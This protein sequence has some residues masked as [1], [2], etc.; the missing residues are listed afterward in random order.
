MNAKIRS[1]GP[2]PLGQGFKKSVLL[3]YH[4]VR[5]VSQHFYLYI[6]NFSILNKSFKYLSLQLAQTISSLVLPARRYTIVYFRYFRYILSFLHSLFY[7]ILLERANVSPSPRIC[8]RQPG[9]PSL[10]HL[11]G[12]FDIWVD[13]VEEVGPACQP[14]VVE[15]DLPDESLVPVALHHLRQKVLCCHIVAEL[16]QNAGLDV[17]RAPGLPYDIIQVSGVVAEV[18]FVHLRGKQ[19]GQV[20][21]VPSGP[22][23]EQVRQSVWVARRRREKRDLAGFDLGQALS[24]IHQVVCQQVCPELKPLR[25]LVV[26]GRVDAVQVAVERF[27]VV[28]VAAFAGQARESVV[29]LN[30]RNV[31]FLRHLQE[32]RGH[33]ALHLRV[34]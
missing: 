1:P 5:H 9:A 7:I 4:F 20:Q 3:L 34:E 16:Q 23:L 29:A 2:M 6:Y 22:V 14:D 26:Y 8:F 11:C 32:Q 21:F 30:A 28:V 13:V 19:I 10:L 31:V 33:E 18:A 27:R 17:V 24:E 15:K 12:L 25:F